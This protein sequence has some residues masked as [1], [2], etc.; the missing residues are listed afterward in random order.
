MLVLVSCVFALAAGAASAHAITLPSR[1]I[2]PLRAEVRAADARVTRSRAALARAARLERA[3]QAKA[4]ILDARFKDAAA[5]LRLV[6]GMQQPQLRAPAEQARD[7][8]VARRDALD[9]ATRAAAAAASSM[10]DAERRLHALERAA[11][12]DPARLTRSGV[13]YRFGSGGPLVTARSIDSYLR[14]KGSP[15]A[16]SGAQ[17]L[18]AGVR[19]RVDPRLIVAIAGAESYFGIITCAPH[20]AW[21]WG[22]PSRPLSFG[23]WA[24]GALAIAQ[25]LRSGY[26]DDGLMSVGQ[27]HLRYAPPGATNDPDG[28]N[29]AWADNV[30]RFLTEQGGDP[31]SLEGPLAPSR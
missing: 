16:G 17:I 6:P 20:N 4:S 13:G 15:M 1:V 23:T 21:G 30:A 11:S 14:S 28:L 8:A 29:Y 19:H 25:G 26:L 31:Q 24:D 9:R 2:E 5:V 7:A 12:A 3:A 10:L 22:C 27:I 18:D